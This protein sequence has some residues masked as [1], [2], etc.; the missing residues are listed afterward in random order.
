MNSGGS[1]KELPSPC[2]RVFLLY[3]DFE[4][5][6]R[7]KLRLDAAAARCGEVQYQVT[8]W[9]SDLLEQPAWAD[10]ALAEALD[11]D[12]MLL[13]L[14]HT[15]FLPPALQRWLE[16]WATC[17]TVPDAAAGLLVPAKTS[18]ATLLL[19]SELESFAR[20]HGL[21]WLAE[22]QSSQRPDPSTA[23]AAM[24]ED[25]RLREHGMTPLLRDVLSG[26][27]PYRFFGLNE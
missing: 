9:R 12:L 14:G 4:L 5:A 7:A 17:R 25:L 19:G 6:R 18:H 22:L 26:P 13:A 2:L 11:A 16:V 15:V 27:A 20:R 10:A 24:L 1:A 23:S 8:P 3:D 21:T